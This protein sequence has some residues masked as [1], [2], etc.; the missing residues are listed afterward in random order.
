MLSVLEFSIWGRLLFRIVMPSESCFTRWLGILY[1]IRHTLVKALSDLDGLIPCDLNFSWPTWT[2]DSLT[3]SPLDP[4]KFEDL[5]RTTWTP[6][7]GRKVYHS[8][9]PRHL[10]PDAWDTLLVCYQYK[11]TW[12]D[13]L[14]MTGG[15]HVMFPCDDTSIISLCSSD[16]LE[17]TLCKQRTTCM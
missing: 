12:Q 7:L 15:I 4:L 16:S 10:E 17:S 8:P 13:D 9:T 1:W 6:D 14:Y 2:W 11:R 5:S 3:P